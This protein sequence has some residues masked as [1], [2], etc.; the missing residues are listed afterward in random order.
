MA[1]DGKE[2]SLYMN[3]VDDKGVDT[4]RK[5]L[6]AEVAALPAST[7]RFFRRLMKFGAT[8]K[9]A[10]AMSGINDIFVSGELMLQT[11]DDRNLG[12]AALLCQEVYQSVPPVQPCPYPP[13]RFDNQ[14]DDHD[15]YAFTPKVFMLPPGTIIDEEESMGI[16]GIW[17]PS[18]NGPHPPESLAPKVRV[19]YDKKM[20]DFQVKE[21]QAFMYTV[22]RGW[23]R[24]TGIYR[25]PHNWGFMVV[26]VSDTIGTEYFLVDEIRGDADESND[27]E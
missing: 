27:N 18:S 4:M 8:L 23:H 7:S 6:K 5:V 16:S 1:L 17:T 11:W 14:V 22:E 2:W 12:V 15:G 9:E 26:R 21:L 25:M 19:D 20:T 10:D 3:G 13:P 24:Q